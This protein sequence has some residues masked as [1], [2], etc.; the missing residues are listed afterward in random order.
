[1]GGGDNIWIFPLSNS[2]KVEVL[3][4][5]VYLHLCSVP[6]G[7]EQGPCDPADYNPSSER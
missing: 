7:L 1:M 5:C 2:L 4:D 3:L 6:A